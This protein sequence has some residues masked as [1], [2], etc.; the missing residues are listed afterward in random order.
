[1]NQSNSPKLRIAVT[2]SNGYLGSRLCDYFAGQN[3]AVYQLTS[4]EDAK[5]KQIRFTLAEG[6]AKKLF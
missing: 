5:E 6:A 4:S 3:Y 2:G 1:M